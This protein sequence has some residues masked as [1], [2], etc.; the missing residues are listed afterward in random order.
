MKCEYFMDKMI[1]VVIPVYNIE[2]YLTEC[3][4]SVLNQ[5]YKN[6]QIILV[7][8]GSTENS[9]NIIEEFLSK[10][11]RVII[12]HQTNMGAGMAKNI[13][14]ELVSGD[15]LSLIDSDDF[16][17]LEFYEK[18]YYAMKQTNA[19]VAQCLISSFYVDGKYEHSYNFYSGKNRVLSVSR[20]L[21]EM[22]YDWKY[23]IFCNKLFKASLLKD[24]RFPVGRKIDDEFFT[25]KLILEAK[26]VVNIN[27]HMYNY[28][29]RKTSV[30][31]N[32]SSEKLFHDRIDCFIERY[33]FVSER[34]KKLKRHF[35]THFANYLQYYRNK[36]DDQGLQN[37]F[38][39]F[40]AQFPIH[41]ENFLE[42]TER[43]LYTRKYN[44]QDD[45]FKGELFD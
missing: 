28:R 45:S 24:N 43:K 13:G 12:V 37:L 34:Y 11:D 31:K 17:E 14:L 44:S 19:D 38:D 27:D 7:D 21:F 35:Y 8:D 18:L 39:S 22:L 4:F 9:A 5:T 6:L 15:L 25:Y 1:S 42:K 3:L 32:S 16:L 33:E 41:D 20:F 30:M 29:M 40:S 2:K 26:T 10:D 23:A 36:V